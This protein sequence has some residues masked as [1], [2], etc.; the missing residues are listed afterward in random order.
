MT[1][2]PQGIGTL[3]FT[4]NDWNN[5]VFSIVQTTAGTGK[6]RVTNNSPGTVNAVISVRGYFNAGTGS[7]F[8]TMASKTIVDT[9]AGVGTGG[10][11]AALGAEQSL[12]F[13]ASGASGV[14]VSTVTAAALQIKAISPTK[15]GWMTLRPA[16]Q[17][18]PYIATLLYQAG[19]DAAAFDLTAPSADGKVTITNHG[20]AAVHLLISVSGYFIKPIPQPILDVYTRLKA[21]GGSLTDADRTTLASYP[22]WQAVVP[23]IDAADVGGA[24]DV[25]VAPNAEEIAEANEDL[26]DDDAARKIPPTCYRADRYITY[27]SYLRQVIMRW[28]HVLKYCYKG[29]KV[30]SIKE[31]YPYITD[32]HSSITNNGL[33]TDAQG[34]K[35]TASY[36]STMQ[37]SLTACTIIVGCYATY[38]PYERY[39]VNGKTGKYTIQQNK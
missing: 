20:D 15:A 2:S 39:A 30:T 28:H 29:G 22:E 18:D 14:P 9:A 19:E 38:N 8:A 26:A 3:K 32:A 37:G 24:A 7:N 4:Q 35:K 23:D 1:D 16:G 36:Y 11:T 27:R 21:N 17:A 34:G 6:V 31:R 25:E 33:T 10:S 5:S 12:T 13:D